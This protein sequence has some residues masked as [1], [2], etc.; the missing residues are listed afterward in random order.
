MKSATLGW[1]GKA[2]AG[3]EVSGDRAGQDPAAIQGSVDGG[4]VRHPAA[5]PRGRDP[6]RLHEKL[7]RNG[8]TR[9]TTVVAPAG[10]GKTTLL[11]QW[12]HDPAEQRRVAW[13]SLDS[14]DDE[15]TRFW[16]YVLTALGQH[17]I[18][19][20]ALQALGAPGLQPVDV[21]LPELLNELQA[22]SGRHVLVLDDYH[23]LSNPDVQEGVEFLLAYLPPS[24]HLV[25]AARADP[26][27]PMPRLR[28]RGE[29]TEIRMSELCF[30]PA[31]AGALVTSVAD[32]DL[33]APTA[34]CC[35]SAPR[36]GPPDCS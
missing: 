36:A 31:E 32:V 1:G 16:T 29:L 3:A 28:A 5:S 26:P 22:S 17:G 15:P 7:L 33:D 14:S 9:V 2:R 35:R 21:A 4:Q 13:V 19:A 30:S 20:A 12:A 27:L 6:S 11:S 24:L 8:G 18:G 25:L 10:W 34:S 23:L